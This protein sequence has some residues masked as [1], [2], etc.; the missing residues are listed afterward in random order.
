MK[1]D[2]NYFI[3]QSYIE[4]ELKNIRLSLEKNIDIAMKNKEAEVVF[5]FT[6]MALIKLGIYIIAREGY[7]VKSRAGPHIKI[8]EIL[9]QKTEME[10]IL[11][12]GNNMRRNRNLDIYSARIEI[13]RSE[14]QEYLK[15]VKKIYNKIFK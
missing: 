7:R 14:A 4:S 13:S 12:I 11:I 9:S 10:D 8:L 3:K 2:K 6:Y 5:H 1:F 15:F